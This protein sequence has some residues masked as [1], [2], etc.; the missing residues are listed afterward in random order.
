MVP[1]QYAAR[2]TDRRPLHKI[3][4][5]A[6]GEHEAMAREAF[7]LL[8]S[9]TRPVPRVPGC[10]T[11]MRLSVRLWIGRSLHNAAAQEYLYRWRLALRSPGFGVPH[12]IGM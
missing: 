2:R 5:E 6:M 9:W 12:E 8:Q 10:D 1:E 3:I 4:A 11:V 7:D